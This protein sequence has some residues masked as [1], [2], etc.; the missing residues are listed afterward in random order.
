MKLCYPRGGFS[1]TYFH[2]SHSRDGDREARA[3]RKDRVIFFV[4]ATFRH[5]LLTLVESAVGNAESCPSRRKLPGVTRISYSFRGKGSRKLDLTQQI[6][7]TS[8]LFPYD[9][10]IG[11]WPRTARTCDRTRIPRLRAI[12]FH[13]EAKK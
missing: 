10:M 5:S 6:Q 3:R 2:A 9:V 7:E 13:T 8:P 11:A 4:G 12:T 1:K